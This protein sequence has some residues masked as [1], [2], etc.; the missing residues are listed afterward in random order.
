[1]FTDRPFTVMY[2]DHF[3]CTGHPF[4]VMHDEQLNSGT[5]IVVENDLQHIVPLRRQGKQCL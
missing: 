2:D 3:T 1:M 5:V 4:T